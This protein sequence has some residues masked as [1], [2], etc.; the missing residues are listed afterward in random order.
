MNQRA[1]HAIYVARFAAEHGLTVDQ[2]EELIRLAHRA[3]T[4]GVRACNAPDPQHK[5]QRAAD[6][7]ATCARALGFTGVDWPG[8]WPVLRKGS[9]DVHLPS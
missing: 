2:V 8:L 3:H 1:Q 6:R 7:F 9:F 4:A 5:E